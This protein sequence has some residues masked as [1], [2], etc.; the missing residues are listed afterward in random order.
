MGLQTWQVW[1]VS[2]S[3]LILSLVTLEPLQSHLMSR[4][5][6]HMR[7]IS[8]LEASKRSNIPYITLYRYMRRAEKKG[9]VQFAT[10]GRWF[11]AP[12][13]VR[14]ED[15]NYYLEQRIERQNSGDLTR[16]QQQA[17]NAL[18]SLQAIRAM[19]LEKKEQAT[20]DNTTDTII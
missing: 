1:Y 18:T 2:L 3:Y 12:L 11:L 10:Y 5:Q 16:R 19:K 14:L 8:L 20:N 4:K 9:L 17:K 7:Y 6:N 13:S 15:W